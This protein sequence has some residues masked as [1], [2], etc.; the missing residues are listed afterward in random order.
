MASPPLATITLGW[1]RSQAR[2]Y[3]RILRS[4]ISQETEY[5]HQDRTKS[6]IKGQHKQFFRQVQSDQV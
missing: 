6:S 5:N 1:G 2:E 4:R 3:Y